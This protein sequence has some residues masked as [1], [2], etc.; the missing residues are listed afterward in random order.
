M[1]T[2]PRRGYSSSIPRRKTSQSRK[3]KNSAFPLWLSWTP[4]CDP[5]EIDYVIPGNDDAIRAIRL[6]AAK[7]AMPVP[8]ELHVRSVLKED[9]GEAAPRRGRLKP[10]QKQQLRP[11]KAKPPLF[12][13]DTRG[14]D[15]AVEE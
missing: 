10:A 1:E 14:L 4:N 2:P 6:F 3:Q 9:L 12:R 8:K 11:R 7:M 5:D 15:E 13:R